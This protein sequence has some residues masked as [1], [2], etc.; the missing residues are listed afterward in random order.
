MLAQHSYLGAGLGTGLRGLDLSRRMQCSAMHCVLHTTASSDCISKAHTC[1]VGI[2]F[3]RLPWAM[4]NLSEL[5]QLRVAGSCK[6]AVHI[7]S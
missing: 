1:V 5:P 3:G 2:V 6:F 7:Q 4:Y